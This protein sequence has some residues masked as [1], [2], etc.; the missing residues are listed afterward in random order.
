MDF[1]LRRRRSLPD[2]LWTLVTGCVVFGLSWYHFFRYRTVDPV[3]FLIAMTALYLC[4][5]VT[6]LFVALR[7]S[8]VFGGET[9]VI[10]SGVRPACVLPLKEVVSIALTREAEGKLTPLWR[11][12]GKAHRSGADS[13]ILTCR[14]GRRYRLAVEYHR[15]F[16][17]AVEAR[18]AEPK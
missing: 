1:S 9:I 18:L 14:D 3:G 12:Y 4:L 6:D 13:L 8:V 10:R 16:Q 5:I 2:I 7:R 17:E 15:K 11:R